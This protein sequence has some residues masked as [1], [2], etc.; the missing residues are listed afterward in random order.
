[1]S[2][3][4]KAASSYVGTDQQGVIG[5]VYEEL[6]TNSDGNTVTRYLK[7]IK[8]GE[9]IVAG[10][11][12]GCVAAGVPNM[13]NIGTVAKIAADGVDKNL[14]AGIALAT[15][16]TG[17]FGWAVCRGLV[18]KA[19]GGPSIAVGDLLQSAGAVAAGSVDTI[20]AGSGTSNDIIGIA[21]TATDS[22]GG[23]LNLDMYIDVL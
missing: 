15:L 23:D 6:Y 13:I 7:V 19:D 17:E 9:A 12:V 1:M 21:L 8:A 14:C 5:K 3:V 16:A 20:T 4:I 18:E 10:D 2:N 22:S 11:L